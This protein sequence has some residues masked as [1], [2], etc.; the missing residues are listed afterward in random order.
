M[1]E[2]FSIHYLGVKN[3]S[4]SMQRPGTEAIRTQF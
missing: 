1:T 4:K 3:G 2:C